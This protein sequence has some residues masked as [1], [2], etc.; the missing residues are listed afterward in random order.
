MIT[1][2]SLIWDPRG[3]I[4]TVRIVTVAD[5]A[6]LAVL[7]TQLGYPTTV[8]DAGH[9]IAYFAADPRSALLGADSDGALVGV[10]SLTACP[11]LQDTGAWARLSAL[12]V[13]ETVR[14]NGAG[15][16]LVRAG[17]EWAR[18]AGCDLMEVTSNRA[19]EAAH[20]FY[21]GLGYVDVCDR[22]ARFTRKLVE[23]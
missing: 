6:R 7:L 8:D 5:A 22:A 19:R 23:T 14:G 9:R 4:V 11:S 12:V 10:V 2:S 16:A 15:R 13:D 20:A 21:R 17:E 1:D 3:M 18:G